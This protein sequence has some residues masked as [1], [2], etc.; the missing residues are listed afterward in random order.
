MSFSNVDYTNTAYNNMLQARRLPE[1]IVN[2]LFDK[3]DNLWKLL[4]YSQS[5]VGQ[6]NV[7]DDIKANMIASTATGDLSNYQ[8]F[9]ELFNTDST[10]LADA[11]LR[12]AVLEIKPVNRTN[13]VVTVVVQCVVNNKATVVSTDTVAVENK[14]FAIAQEVV[15]SLNGAELSGLKGALW[16]DMSQDRGTGIRK[17]SYSDNFSGYEIVFGAYI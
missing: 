11:Q 6:P 12:L 16:L 5:T 2:Q 10:V 3:A 8:V 17:V 14:A 9:F 7:P 1:S 15:T 13:V 4:Y